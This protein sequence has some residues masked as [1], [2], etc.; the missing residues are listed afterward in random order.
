M[1]KKIRGVKLKKQDVNKNNGKDIS[2]TISKIQDNER[3]YTIILV[4]FFMAIFFIIGFVSLRIRTSSFFEYSNNFNGAYL[5]LTSR[6]VF[7][8]QSSKVDD[9]V[10]LLSDGENL[11]I[12]NTTNEDINYKIILVEDYDLEKECGC[13]NNSFNKNDIKFSID[14]K[15]VR[16][17][18]S[19]EMVITTGFL[20]MGKKENINLK[21]WIDHNSMNIGHFHG[22]VLFE[23]IE[24]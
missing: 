22:K 6:V 23:K 15:N 4:V 19:E 7:L 17:F 10:G 18:S 24:D 9:S 1:G 16:T 5:S 3:K 12:Y 20:E 11:V 13:S 8:D 2:H 21:I 14:G